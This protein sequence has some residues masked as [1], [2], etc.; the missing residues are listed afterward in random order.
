MQRPPGEVWNSW[1]STG[2]AKVMVVCRLWPSTATV[3]LT[4]W[5][6]F[7]LP[8]L[9][10]NVTLLWPAGKMTLEGT[11]SMG[12]LLAMLTTTSVVRA[13]SNVK[14]HLPDTL[15]AIAVGVHWSDLGCPFVAL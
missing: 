7:T 9:A 4:V 1:Q 13:A 2:G 3:M 15:L 11:E 10:L 14:A 5:L 6:A 8:E 12:L